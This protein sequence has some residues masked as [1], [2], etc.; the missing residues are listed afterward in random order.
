MDDPGEYIQE[1]DIIILVFISIYIQ[2]NK[3]K[4]AQI[5][6]APLHCVS[7]RRRGFKFTYKLKL[8]STAENQTPGND[9][10]AVIYS[11]VHPSSIPDQQ[12]LFFTFQL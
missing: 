6:Y 9:T 5:T 12:V 2:G 7:C 1:Q 3:E 11:S 10:E 8:T 4:W